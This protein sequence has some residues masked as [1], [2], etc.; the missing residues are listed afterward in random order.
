MDVG[1]DNG[2]HRWERA[3]GLNLSTDTAGNHKVV[4]VGGDLGATT[5]EELRGE[6][7]MFRSAGAYDLAVGTGRVEHADSAGLET[8]ADPLKTARSFD[9]SLRLV[10]N[11]EPILK[12]V[13]DWELGAKIPSI[14]IGIAQLFVATG[15]RREAIAGRSQQ[16]ARF[17]GPFDLRHRATPAASC[18]E[19][20][21][22]SPL[23]LG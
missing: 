6:L 7:R 18:A 21:A 20:A 14:G 1:G 4:A 22:R 2:L 3:M 19:V 11:Q 15:W 23:E 8:L 12:T 16:T 10:R 5:G 9:G 13:K 17:T